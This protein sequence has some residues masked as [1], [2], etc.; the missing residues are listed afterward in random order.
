MSTGRSQ[1]EA[2]LRQ[3]QE[4]LAESPDIDPQVKQRLTAMQAEIMSN[5][6]G[7]KAPPVSPASAGSEPNAVRPLTPGPSPAKGRG[8]EVGSSSLTRRLTDAALYFE[9]SHPQ[10]STTIGSLAGI[11]GQMGF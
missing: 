3:L 2:T 9:E 4:Q 11:I 6:Q 5:L 10:L 7:S 8:E 1:I